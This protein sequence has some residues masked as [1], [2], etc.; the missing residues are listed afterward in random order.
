MTSM[1]GQGEMS[2]MMHTGDQYQRGSMVNVEKTAIEPAYFRKLFGL[3]VQTENLYPVQMA[4][5]RGSGKARSPFGRSD[6]DHDPDSNPTSTRTSCGIGIPSVA[7]ARL[8]Q[9]LDNEDANAGNSQ[10]LRR[11]A[12]ED[13]SS[14]GIREPKF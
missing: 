13:K 1:S 10:K 6:I 8:S 5:S 7:S 11:N 14:R 4:A 2:Q 12:T 9:A 3:W